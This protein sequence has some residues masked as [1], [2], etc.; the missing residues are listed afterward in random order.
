MPF[1]VGLTVCF[2]LTWS[3]ISLQSFYVCLLG[4]PKEKK[5][6]KYI[7]AIFFVLALN[8]GGCALKDRSNIDK[9]YE[10]ASRISKEDPN[11][12][13]KQKGKKSIVYHDKD[14]TVANWGR[15]GFWPTKG[16]GLYIQIKTDGLSV[17]EYD[18]DHMN[19]LSKGDYN[20]SQ[21]KGS[22]FDYTNNKK[23]G[24]RIIISNDGKMVCYIRSNGNW[25]KTCYDTSKIKGGMKFESFPTLSE[26][27]VGEEEVLSFLELVGKIRKRYQ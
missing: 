10:F 23:V 18:C 8:F 12:F 9:A 19:Q 1:R 20:L 4:I 17:S 5:M 11:E 16:K 14:L 22:S 13:T 24:E 3:E 2:C 7:S 25:K 6:R 26:R 27:I 15:F 21:L